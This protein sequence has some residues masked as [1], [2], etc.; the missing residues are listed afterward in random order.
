MIAS[1]DATVATRPHS[2]VV[3]DVDLLS[4]SRKADDQG[5]KKTRKAAPMRHQTM[6]RFVEKATAVEEITTG[7]IIGT[8]SIK[9]MAL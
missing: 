6:M 8:A 1:A 9:A 5:C 3:T 2:S 4:F 7:L